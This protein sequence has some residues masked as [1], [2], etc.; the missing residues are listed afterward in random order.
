MA[1]ISRRE[2]RAK[3][4]E[5]LPEQ[6]VIE[7]KQTK[8]LKPLTL[9]QKAYM[10]SIRANIVTF[11]IGSAGTG[12]TFIAGAMAADMLRAG[13]ID[14]L[15]V[16]RPGVE[17]GKDWGALPGELKDKFAPF[18]EPIVDVLNERLGKSAVEYLIKH[19]RIQFKPL[20][21][22]RGKTF[23]RCFYLLDEAQ[24]TTPTQMKLFLTRI[25]EN[26]KVVVDGDIQ[27]KDIRGLSGL[28]DAV[29]RFGLSDFFGVVEF[30]IDDCVR[31]GITR[32][33]L[34]GYEHG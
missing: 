1:K 15:V 27:Q 10:A 22:M 5:I 12:K 29:K 9:N 24:N 18:M 13:E 14:A 2:K 8:P 11:A 32:E 19:E 25:G 23:S 16:T 26:C 21:F 7:C 6:P 3:S 30:G 34:K 33:I 20:E 31:S 4:V 17:A 28:E